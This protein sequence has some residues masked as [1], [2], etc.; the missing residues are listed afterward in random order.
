MENPHNGSSC[1]KAVGHVL[2]VNT[3]GDVHPVE[4]FELY[5]P[6]LKKSLQQNFKIASLFSNAFVLIAAE[7]LAF[8]FTVSGSWWLDDP[9]ICPAKSDRFETW[10]ATI[11]KRVEGNSNS[12]LFFVGNYHAM[13]NSSYTAPRDRLTVPICVKKQWKPRWLRKQDG[14]GSGDPVTGS[15]AENGSGGAKKSTA[16][17]W[18]AWKWNSLRCWN[19]DKEKAP[20]L[21][22][23]CCWKAS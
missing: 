22:L 9:P 10:T 18:I 8:M 1:V 4:G 3:C 11:G 12:P 6:L 14:R 7:T 20:L 13:F 17:F 2:H 5:G 23:F 19:K 21:S 16:Q 15:T